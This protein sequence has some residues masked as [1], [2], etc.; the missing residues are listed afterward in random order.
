MKH[1]RSFI[2]VVSF[3]RHVFRLSEDTVAA[4][5]ESVI[6]GSAIEFR[7]SQVT[8]S[9]F[10]FKVSCMQVG[11]HILDL[12]SFKCSSFK[13]FFHLWGH[14]GPNWRREFSLWKKQCDAEWIIVSP[15]KRR[16][17]LGLMAMH[18]RPLKSSLKSGSSIRNTLTFAS[19]QQYEV[20][21]GYRC[22]VSH[23]ELLTLEQAG[24]TVPSPERAIISAPPPAELRWTTATP[25]ITFVMVSRQ[26]SPPG[27]PGADFQIAKINGTSPLQQV[28]PAAADDGGWGQPPAAADGGGWEPEAAPEAPAADPVQDQESMV[29][30]QPS[31][32]SSDSVH[33]LVDLD[34]QPQ[35]DIEAE[36]ADQAPPAPNLDVVM[37]N[38]VAPDA[39]MAPVVQVPAAEPEEDV[40][41]VEEAQDD[42]PMRLSH[43]NPLRFSLATSLL[44]LPGFFMGLLCRRFYPGHVLLML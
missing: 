32:S 40:L 15:S 12:R 14:G 8:D 17:S 2:M 27:S 21:K 6:G 9:V 31:P 38:P 16:A 19:L 44:G 3:G 33:E 28:V 24:Y 1:R 29:I 36:P 41:G 42:N 5:L 43:T 22:P 20:C 13:C 23:D 30:D 35:G 37:A 25:H 10:S 39:D 4:A 7:V 26:Q 18:S 11:F 34:P